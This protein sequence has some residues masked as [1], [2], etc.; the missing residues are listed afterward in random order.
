MKS[1]LLDTFDY[2]EST[3]IF[4]IKKNKKFKTHVDLNL[5]VRYYLISYLRRVK[6]KDKEAT[7]DEI[8]LAYIA[9]A[10]KWHYARK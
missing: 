8:V 1:F 4:T 3:K 6:R 7:F 9:A 5:R 2:D 10:Q